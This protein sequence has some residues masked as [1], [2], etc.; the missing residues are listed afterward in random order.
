MVPEGLCLTTVSPALHAPLAPFAATTLTRGPLSSS[1]WTWPSSPAPNSNVTVSDEEDAR[2]LREEIDNITTTGCTESQVRRLLAGGKT[3]LHRLPKGTVRRPLSSCLRMQYKMLSHL[4]DIKTTLRAQKAIIEQTKDK[5]EALQEKEAFEKEKEALKAEIEMRKK[6]QQNSLKVE[7]ELR[8]HCPRAHEAYTS[9]INQ[10]N[11]VAQLR[12]PSNDEAI[13]R[14]SP[15]A[16]EL[17]HKKLI[18]AAVQRPTATAATTSRNAQPQ[19]SLL[20]SD[21]GALT[22]RA[23]ARSPS[24]SGQPPGAGTQSAPMGTSLDRH[25]LSTVG[26]CCLQLEYLRARQLVECLSNLSRS[27]MQQSPSMGNRQPIPQ[28]GLSDYAVQNEFQKLVQ[29]QQQLLPQA[30]ADAG[31]PGDKDV[32]AFTMND[33]RKILEAVS[34]RFPK[35]PSTPGQQQQLQNQQQQQQQQLMKA[36]KRNSTSPGEEHDQQSMDLSPPDAKRPRRSPMDN[37]MIPKGTT[38]MP[39]PKHRARRYSPCRHK[40]PHKGIKALPVIFSNNLPRP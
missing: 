16:L 17:D 31:I 4:C 37:P 36:G 15:P 9:M 25:L 21:N 20:I 19:P 40:A 32:S 13:A 22:K 28:P 14:S 30:K 38:P 12:M 6:S 7:E 24:P 10:Y 35:N 11:Y 3:F 18:A 5:S 39:Y 27:M 2:R 8:E 23:A 1:T 34:R 26:R 33:K 29:Q